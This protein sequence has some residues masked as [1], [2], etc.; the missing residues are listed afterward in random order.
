V[1]CLAKQVEGVRAHT[2]GQI[3]RNICASGHS[4][5]RSR[6][7]K[8][9]SHVASIRIGAPQ[10]RIDNGARSVGARHVETRR[11]PPTAS[12]GYLLLSLARRFAG[13]PAFRA[14]NLQ[15]V[16]CAAPAGSLN[17]SQTSTSFP[18][19]PAAA[20]AMWHDCQDAHSRQPQR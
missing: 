14:E 13:R 5:R 15:P 16:G 10:I 19:V 12:P 3:A 7:V 4:A 8:I 9:S 6:L 20:V 1:Q 18:H 17:L 2:S 11:V